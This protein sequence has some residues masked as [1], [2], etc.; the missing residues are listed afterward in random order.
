MSNEVKV[1]LTKIQFTDAWLLSF[2]SYCV[3]KNHI[4]AGKYIT[5]FQGIAMKSEWTEECR[6]TVAKIGM[7]SKIEADATGL[8]KRV[9]NGFSCYL[10]DET[11]ARE[12]LLI[13]HLFPSKD[14]VISSARDMK[15]AGN[16]S[17]E[18]HD[19]VSIDYGCMPD[20][21]L[22][23]HGE[24]LY[25]CRYTNILYLLDRYINDIVSQNPGITHESLGKVMKWKMVMDQEKNTIEFRKTLMCSFP[26]QSSPC[27]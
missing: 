4:E 19:V 1:T 13:K 3:A 21:I 11:S 18:D 20:I 8:N 14:V 10:S 27:N 17:D 23:K 2:N 16:S 6:D 26:S 24:T 7:F 5:Y 15:D 22:I 12:E 25:W 9:Q